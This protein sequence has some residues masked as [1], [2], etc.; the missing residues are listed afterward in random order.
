V[1]R[2]Q[3]QIEDGRGR[4]RDDGIVEETWRTLDESLKS[5]AMDRDLALS[6]AKAQVAQA[7]PAEVVERVRK[8]L[9]F[10]PQDPATRAAWEH[11]PQEA[12]FRHSYGEAS[13]VVLEPGARPLEEWWRSVR[14]EVRYALLKGLYIERNLQVIHAGTKNCGGCGGTGFMG[15]VICSACEGSRL[16]RIV[17]YR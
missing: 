14:D 3:A 17:I 9:N 13:W 7:L 4:A 2:L 5:L 15:E 8:R 11:R 12:R 10:S 6:D 16:Q 1:Q